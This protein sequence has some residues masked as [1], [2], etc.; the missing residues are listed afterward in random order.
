MSALAIEHEIMDLYIGIP[1]R[2][3]FESVFERRAGKYY[4]TITYSNKN[5]EDHHLIYG[6]LLVNQANFHT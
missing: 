5:D 3:L 2:M 4:R 6:Y 1:E